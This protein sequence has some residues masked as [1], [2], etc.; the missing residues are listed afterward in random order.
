MSFDIVYCIIC[1]LQN[2]DMQWSHFYSFKDA[3]KINYVLKSG[4]RVKIIKLNWVHSLCFKWTKIHLSP[5]I[6]RKFGT[7]NY[8]FTFELVVPT[9]KLSSWLKLHLYSRH[10]AKCSLK[11]WVD[12][13]SPNSIFSWTSW[14]EKVYTNTNTCD[15]IALKSENCLTVLAL[16]LSKST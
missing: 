4:I 12:D 2:F 3:I 15:W 9:D 16:V 6:F 14:H 1:E 8:P 5:V 13:I 10:H 11:Q 7:S